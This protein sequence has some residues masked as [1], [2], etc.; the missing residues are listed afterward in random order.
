MSDEI[1]TFKVTEKAL[2]SQA[3][4]FNEWSLAMIEEMINEIE[5]SLMGGNQPVEE[6]R[7]EKMLRFLEQDDVEPGAAAHRLTE[8]RS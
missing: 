8:E 4:T 2:L 5:S 6:D 1:T 3:V 7:L